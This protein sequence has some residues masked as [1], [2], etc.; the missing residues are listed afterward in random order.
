[1]R[2][3]RAMRAAV[4]AAWLVMSLGIAATSGCANILGLREAVDD[5]DCVLN[6]DCAPD[7]ACIFRVCSPQCQADKDCPAT[8]RCLR[9]ENGAACVDSLRAGCDK[10]CPL[11][12]V[13]DMT[14]NVCR[15]E[16]NVDADCLGGQVCT[17]RLCRGSDTGRDPPT[18]DAGG[19]AR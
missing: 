14:Q 1:M 13:C 19:G 9:T 16:C 11:G 8:A 18:I 3:A 2:A 17:N 7:K 15:N 12:T 5:G 10:M 4:G 6:S